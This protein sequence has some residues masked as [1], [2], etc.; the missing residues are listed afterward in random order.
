MA[1]ARLAALLACLVA[2]SA[3]T[4]EKSPDTSLRVAHQGLLAA[5]YSPDGAHLFSGSF[6]HGGALWDQTRGER[7]FDWNISADEYSA[8]S[9]ADF[10]EDGQFIAVSTGETVTIWNATSGEVLTHLQSPAQALA[11]ANTGA[12]WTSTTNNRSSDDYWARPGRIL[13]LAFSKQYLLLGLENQVALLVDITRRSIIGAL[14]HEDVISAVAMDDNAQFGLTGS[15]DGKATVWSLDSGKPVSTYQAASAISFVDISPTGE[16]AIVA[17]Y[18]GPVNIINTASGT[19]V[20]TLFKKNP[21]V[22]AARFDRIRKRLL[23]G[24]SQERVMLFDL[25]DDRLLQRW[26]V[27]SEGPWHKAAVIDVAFGDAGDFAVASDGKAY[28]LSE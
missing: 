1:L 20:T 2:V 13:D 24:T 15:R 21:G 3:C 22:T 4:P 17:E 5:A 18:Q 12:I 11:I 23:I 14:P 27:P 6:Q 10:S 7:L 19:L 26:R 8:F 16:V 25:D 9:S 28:R